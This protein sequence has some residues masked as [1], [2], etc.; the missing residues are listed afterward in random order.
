[1]TVDREVGTA[2]ARLVDDGVLTGD[3]RDAVV[4]AVARERAARLAPGRLLAEIAA[5]AGAGLVLAGLVVLLDSSWD[6]LGTAGKMLAL[7]L[8]SAGLIAGGVALAGGRRGLFQP[9]G[10]ART[11]P[12]RLAATLFALAP[13]SA[14]LLVGLAIDE[15]GDDNAFVWA[16]LVGTGLAVLGYTALPSLMG[17]VAGGLFSAPAVAA[18]LT[19]W[20]DL[21]DFGMGIGLLVLAGIWF[22][23]GRSGRAAPTWAGYVIAMVIAVVGAELTGDLHTGWAVA[24]LLATAATCFALYFTD[25]NPVLVL[26]GGALVTIAVVQ[27]VWEW[28]D[29][30]VGAAVLILV[31]G[32]AVLGVGAVRLGRG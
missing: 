14:A 3:Q 29:H 30:S 26:G 15:R 1:M 27:A 31:A 17:L 25:R 18:M 24:F 2:L 6:D 11:G 12:A 32:A 5:Y 21:D 20:A 9:D 10:F 13:V 8:V 7:A 4:A 16:A 19:V 28:T 23:A 22:A